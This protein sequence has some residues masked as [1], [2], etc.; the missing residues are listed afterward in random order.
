[1]RQDVANKLNIDSNGDTLFGVLKYL[2]DKGFLKPETNVENSIT[3]EGL[4][5]VEKDFP[6]LLFSLGSSSFQ[7]PPLTITVD[8]IDSFNQVKNVSLEEVKA[9]VPL[10]YSEEQ[11]QNWFEI[12]IGEPIHK[13]DWGGETNDLFSSRLLIN[14]KRKN[15]AFLLKGPGIGVK[16]LEISYCGKN[17]DQIQRLFNAPAELFIIQFIGSI[18]EA[19]I[20][21]AKSKTLLLRH[22]GINAQVCIIDGYDT[23]RILKAYGKIT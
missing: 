9:L 17:G 7:E 2:E 16:T 19:V 13:K 8:E 12:I 11:I 14:G 21:E 10:N 3:S 22:R 5:E 4:E 6:N 15:S 18:S 23:S 20:E 1:M